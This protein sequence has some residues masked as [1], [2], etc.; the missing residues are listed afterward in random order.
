MMLTP[1]DQIEAQLAALPQ[2]ADAPP[3]S[4]F[5]SGALDRLGGA[6][7][8]AS[9]AE[10][11]RGKADLQ[12]LGAVRD[13]VSRPDFWRNDIKPNFDAA[14]TRALDLDNAGSGSFVRHNAYAPVIEAINEGRPWNDRVP[15]PYAFTP[16]SVFDDATQL[17]RGQPLSERGIK[18]LVWQR[19]H[20][21]QTKNPGLAGNIPKNEAELEADALAGQKA[22]ADWAATLAR[23]TGPLG[24]LA[25][26]A[27]GAIGGLA[28]PI[29]LAATA[30]GFPETSALRSGG[31]QLL[32]TFVREGALNGA[33]DLAELPGRMQRYADIG[34]PYTAGQAAEEV[35]GA[36][37]L[38]GLIPA[39]IKGAQ[40]AVR[41]RVPG[42]A[43]Y[44]AAAADT[45]SALDRRPLLDA[46]DAAHPDPS[47]TARTARTLVEDDTIRAEQN[48]FTKDAAGE[49]RHRVNLI[50]AMRALDDGRPDLIPNMPV[51]GAAQDIV[52]EAGRVDIGSEAPDMPAPRTETPREEQLKLFDSPAKNSEPFRQQSQDLARELSPRK[53]I[54]P[55]SAI[56]QKNSDVVPDNAKSIQLPEFGPAQSEVEALRSLD[57]TAPMAEQPQLGLF[58]DGHSIKSATAEI[59]RRARAVERLRGC[60]TGE[61]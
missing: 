56:A 21:L 41:P 5:L 18:D 51:E 32:R 59:E 8:D 27:G 1:D 50:E 2:P 6:M 43:D 28:D 3:P 47:P 60:V 24:G 42:F 44:R 61:G 40:L 20:E 7:V 22:D 33:I 13:E 14:M 38:G 23:N 54:A 9:Q 45:F 19:V 34:E 12:T 58:G 37:L 46:F 55:A 4:H 25:Q 53:E 36:V 49:D 39:G 16:L 52:P 11:D 30:I 10:V 15:N 29:N 17:I 57:Q 35:G 31:A 48:P 26:F